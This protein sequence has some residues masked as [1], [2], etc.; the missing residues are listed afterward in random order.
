MLYNVIP[1]Q[2]KVCV[3][4]IDLVMSQ[5]L[6]HID[7]MP[8]FYILFQ[9]ICIRCNDWHPAVFTEPDPVRDRMYAIITIHNYSP[10]LI[11]KL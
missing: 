10:S 1:Y 3:I 11:D 8:A 4:G 2:I 6:V 7:H 5:Y 9:M